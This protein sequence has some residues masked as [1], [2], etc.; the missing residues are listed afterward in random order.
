M[1]GVLKADKIVEG[2]AKVYHE[3]DKG[4]KL[5]KHR[6]PILSSRVTYGPGT[7]LSK[8]MKR[9]SDEEVRLP[10]LI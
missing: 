8:V 2:V 3:G 4:R 10:F 6:W 7:N 9:Q 1:P 5:P